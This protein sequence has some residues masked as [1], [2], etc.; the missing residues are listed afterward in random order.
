MFRIQRQQ[1]IS[2]SLGS[3]D[4]PISNADVYTKMDK[5]MTEMYNSLFNKFHRSFYS[6]DD[7]EVL[8]NYRTTVPNGIMNTIK[9]VNNLI[10]IDV[11]KAF[12]SAN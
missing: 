4:I 2:D 7:L 5:V 1:I 8:N 9:N 6:K 10:E 11:R 12:T 3:G